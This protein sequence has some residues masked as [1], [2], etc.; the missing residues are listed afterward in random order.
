MKREPGFGPR[1]VNRGPSLRLT[2]H[3]YR[4]TRIPT[5]HSGSSTA[6]APAVGA[7]IQVEVQ[8]DQQSMQA[9]IQTKLWPISLAYWC[10]TVQASQ[11]QNC[12]LRNGVPF[13]ETLPHPARSTGNPSQ[14]M[15]PDCLHQPA[16]GNCTNADRP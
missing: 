11:L 8:H 1:V 15:Q 14:Q 7:G 4:Q 6:L 3:L 9:P 2:P 5:L 10:K 12:A 13:Q 16:W